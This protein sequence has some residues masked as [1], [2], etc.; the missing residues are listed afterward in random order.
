MPMSEF[1]FNQLDKS[2][3]MFNQSESDSNGTR[4]CMCVDVLQVL[5]DT[6]VQS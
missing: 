2:A 3:S 5:L 6:L 1:V 4:P